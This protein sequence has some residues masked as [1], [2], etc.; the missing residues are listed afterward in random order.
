MGIMGVHGGDGNLMEVIGIH[1]STSVMHR[2]KEVPL[3]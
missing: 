2:L 1:K 3:S